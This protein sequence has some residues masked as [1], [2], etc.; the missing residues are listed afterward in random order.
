MEDQKENLLLSGIS[1]DINHSIKEKV[2]LIYE[3]AKETLENALKIEKNSK[4]N[5]EDLLKSSNDFHEKPRDIFN[6]AVAESDNLEKKIQ[7]KINFE[8]NEIQKMNV[9]IKNI[10]DDNENLYKEILGV[11]KRLKDIEEKIGI[12]FQV[13][14][15]N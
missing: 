5:Y 13:T 10:K 2:N 3:M 8:K 11:Q 6:H 15:V 14:T 4:L 7:N 12:N 9:D 1:A